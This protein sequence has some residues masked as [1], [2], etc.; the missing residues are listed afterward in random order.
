MLR[1][2]LPPNNLTIRKRSPKRL[3]IVSKRS[4][5][6]YS[7]K[8]PSLSQIKQSIPSTSFRSMSSKYGTHV[9]KLTYRLA[10][11]IPVGT[12]VYALIG[13]Y[14]PMMKTKKEKLKAIT[15]ITFK[16]WNGTYLTVKEKRILPYELYLYK[17]AMVSGSG[18]DPV[19]VFV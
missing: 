14:Y 1:S 8:L 4:T 6:K 15:P 7:T 3:P 10:N 19:Y 16:E 9:K 18:A 13:Q 11:T 2:L 12:T 5:K 17:N